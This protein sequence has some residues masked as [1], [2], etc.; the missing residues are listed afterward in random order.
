MTKYFDSRMKQ[1]DT[2][3]EGLEATKLAAEY[4]KIKTKADIDELSEKANVM[5]LE[6]I[7]YRLDALNQN[8]VNI[9]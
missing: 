1:A 7:N 9:I 8:F 4:T 6:K 3:L 5:G 2:I